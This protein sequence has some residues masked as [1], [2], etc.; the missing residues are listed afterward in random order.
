[1]HNSQIDLQKLMIHEYVCAHAC[2]EFKTVNAIMRDDLLQ[3][4]PML[5]TLLSGG[6]LRR[7]G[8]VRHITMPEE[9]V[10]QIKAPQ[11]QQPRP[12]SSADGRTHSNRVG[13]LGNEHV[14]RP[15]N[16]LRQRRPTKDAQVNTEPRRRLLKNSTQEEADTERQPQTAPQTAI[17]GGVQEPILLKKRVQSAGGPSVARTE[18]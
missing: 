13:P 7:D 14:D 16:A 1:M 3:L 6:K 5:I 8:P 9:F 11:Q 12:A 15:D 18:E 10:R 17:G 4:P 2:T